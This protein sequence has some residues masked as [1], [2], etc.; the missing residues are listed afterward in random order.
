LGSMRGGLQ[1]TRLAV[2]VS[3]S[4]GGSGSNSAPGGSGGDGPMGRHQHHHQRPISDFVAA[5]PNRPGPRA[6]AGKAARKETPCHL[7]DSAGGGRGADGGGG[8]S[9]GMA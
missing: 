2:S 7:L 8:G 1:I 5:P 6:H 9:A 4:G 3:Y